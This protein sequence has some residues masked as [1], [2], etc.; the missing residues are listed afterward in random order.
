MG[1]SLADH[2]TGQCDG[3]TAAKGAP[4]P[5]EVAVGASPRRGW[6]ANLAHVG[7]SHLTLLVLGF[8]L[9]LVLPLHWSS[10]GVVAALVWSVG[11]HALLDRGWPVR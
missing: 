10:M 6:Q 7:Q 8:L 5:A 11:I 3:Q 9:W 4:S 1:H 2:A